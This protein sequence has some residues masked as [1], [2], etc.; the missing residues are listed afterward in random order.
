MV[1]IPQHLEKGLF[2]DWMWSFKENKYMFAVS[3]GILS[4]MT[5][6]SRSD[7]QRQMAKHN[8]AM[9]SLKVNVSVTNSPPEL[10]HRQA[11]H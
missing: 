10:Y 1:L 11:D 2:I 8:Q 7:E 5:V 4:E 9:T 3:H 6:D